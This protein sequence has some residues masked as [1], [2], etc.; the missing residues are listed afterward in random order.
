MI[1][2][3]AR[4]CAARAPGR[5]AAL[6]TSTYGTRS[7]GS[8]FTK[9]RRRTNTGWATRFYATGR[10]VHSS[11]HAPPG[12]STWSTPRP[13]ATA[14]PTSA[15]DLI[16]GVPLYVPHPTAAGGSLINPAAFTIPQDFRQGSLGRNSLR[17]FP[18]YQVDL[19]LGRK[20]HFTD[21]VTLQFRTAVFNLFNRANLAD[22]AGHDASLGTRLSPTDPLRTNAT[23]GHPASMYGRS[24]LGGA[25][26]TFDSFHHS[27]GPRR[28]QFSLK[29]EF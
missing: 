27:G 26:S 25:G 9:Y 3:R 14:S 24:L 8:F 2:R 28:I 12:P 16:A 6:P 21:D 17:G 11:S 23:F 15:P 20:F 5:S 13:S 18:L 4:S 7:A 1:P 29:F 22:P 10:S 19:A